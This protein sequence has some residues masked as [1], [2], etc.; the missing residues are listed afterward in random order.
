MMTKREK[1]ERKCVRVINGEVILPVV[2]LG[3]QENPKNR[4]LY[5]L[6]REGKRYDIDPELYDGPF[7]AYYW[8]EEEQ[9]AVEQY[10]YKAL[11]DFQS[12]FRRRISRKMEL[13]RYDVMGPMTYDKIEMIKTEQEADR[14]LSMSVKKQNE[15]KEENWPW[16]SCGLFI[17]RSE[18]DVVSTLKES[19]QVYKRKIDQEI[20]HP[21]CKTRR[22][23]MNIE[24]KI[25][26]AET[27]Q[28]AVDI[29]E[30]FLPEYNDKVK[31]NE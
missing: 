9:Q 27:I 15:A 13:Y 22:H 21:L 16:L 14:F 8:D 30:S 12:V 1:A 7:I 26:N 23:R 29:Y 10:T 2:E 4:S 31:S 17:E 6:Y 18:N 25:E 24:Y 3:K 28:E 19:A 5:P 11:E 20:N